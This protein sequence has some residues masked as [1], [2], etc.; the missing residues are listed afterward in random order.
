M[1]AAAVVNEQLDV[2]LKVIERLQKIESLPVIRW[3]P[4]R[5]REL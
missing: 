2:F 3:K 5:A 1:K 4:L